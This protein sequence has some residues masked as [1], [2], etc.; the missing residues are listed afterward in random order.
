MEL[1]M[2]HHYL[3]RGFTDEYLLNLSPMRKMFYISSMKLF[4]EEEEAKYRALAGGES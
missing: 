4:Y 1:Y 2:L 3:Q